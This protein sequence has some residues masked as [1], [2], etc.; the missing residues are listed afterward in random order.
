MESHMVRSLLHIQITQMELIGSKWFR[1]E[2]WKRWCARLLARITEGGIPTTA[3]EAPEDAME[4]E[5]PA[6]EVCYVGPIIFHFN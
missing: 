5:S 3:G 1:V 2:P 4:G 6:V